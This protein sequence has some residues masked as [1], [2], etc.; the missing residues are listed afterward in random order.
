MD[1]FIIKIIIA[2]IGISLI[3]SILGCFIV[4]KKMAYFGDS[5][6][7]ASLLGIAIG[8]IFSIDI[9]LMIL[10]IT[11]AFALILGY[12]QNKNILSNDAL[13]GILAHAGISLAMVVVSFSHVIFDLEGFLFGSLLF[14]ENEDIFLIYLSLFIIYPIIFF[15]WQKFILLTLNSDIACSMGINPAIYRMI[16]TI[17]I[18]LTIAITIKITGVLLVTSL[19]IIPASIAR[20]MSK[21]PNQM[22][23]FSTIISVFSSILGVIL[24]Y[25][26]DLILGPIIITIAIVIFSLV[27][28]VKSMTIC[29]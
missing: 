15:N 14:V 5:L 9:N 4:W 19:L 27:V 17:L 13:L 7:H 26:F 3:T 20:I 18:A 16:F 25:E 29:K 24:S 2:A 22:L 12:L 8:I 11:I 1:E 10:A 28:T 6:A 21:S 23:L